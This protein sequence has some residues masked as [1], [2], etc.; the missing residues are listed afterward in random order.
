MN[1]SKS[2]LLDTYVISF[3]K[4]L[5]MT[6]N[7]ERIVRTEFT[8]LAKAYLIPERFDN[9][10]TTKK[11]ISNRATIVTMETDMSGVASADIKV[12]DYNSNKV[13]YDYLEINNTKVSDNIFQNIVTFNGVQVI[14]PPT[15]LSIIVDDTIKAYINGVKYSQ[16]YYTLDYTSLPNTIKI[17]FNESLLGFRIETTDEIHIAGKFLLI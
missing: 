4:T 10:P 16:N 15:Q 5:E 7:Q 11:T 2:W 12:N 9:E 3:D 8:M 17:T 1:L 6:D 13:L 14:Q